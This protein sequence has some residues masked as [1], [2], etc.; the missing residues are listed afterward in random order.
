MLQRIHNQPYREERIEDGLER[1]SDPVSVFDMARMPNSLMCAETIHVGDD[2]GVNVPVYLM[3]GDE[4]IFA[5][6]VL[7]RRKLMRHHPAVVQE[8]NK[9]WPL[10]F[11][12]DDSRQVVA[13]T[14]VEFSLSRD[15]YAPSGSSTGAFNRVID[16][17]AYIDF[18]MKFD[19]VLPLGIGGV[20]SFGSVFALPGN[21]T[22]AD[23]AY[24]ND[25]SYHRASLDWIYDSA[26]SPENRDRLQNRSRD[27]VRSYTP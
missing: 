16:R 22:A 21:L 1:I 26:L 8:L 9:F 19:R 7:H 23:L 12:M 5:Q 4:Q 18:Y 2:M 27:Q 20:G 15:L 10:L 11:G 17:D 25:E 3:D 13:E 24:L 14:R 6:E